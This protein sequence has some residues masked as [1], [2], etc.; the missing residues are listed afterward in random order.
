MGAR[1]LDIDLVPGLSELWCATPVHLHMHAFLEQ[2]LPDFQWLT[3]QRFFVGLVEAFRYPSL[4]RS[5][6]R[7]RL[8]LLRAPFWSLGSR[9]KDLILVPPVLEIEQVN[10][11]DMT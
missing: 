5:C 3:L 6:A 9:I 4:R 7:D 1:H 11:K 10:I 8:Q 2:V